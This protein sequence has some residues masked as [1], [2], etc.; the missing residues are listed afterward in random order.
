MD[1]AWKIIA[2]ALGLYLVGALFV[3]VGLG[4]AAAYLKPARALLSR[5]EGLHLVWR[6]L[7]PLVLGVT[8]WLLAQAVGFDGLGLGWTDDYCEPDPLFGGC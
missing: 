3:M 6:S 4:L 8:L 1:L 5:Y 7:I 2:A